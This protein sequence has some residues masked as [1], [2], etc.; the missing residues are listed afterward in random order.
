MTRRLAVLALL[1]LAAACHESPTD[2]LDD[3]ASKPHGRLSGIVT[4]GPNCPVETPTP[5]PTQP[6]AYSL[7]KILVYNEAKTSLLFTVDIDQFGLYTILL[8]PGRY[9][10]DLKGSGIDKTADLPKVVEIK[11]NVTTTLNVAIDTGIR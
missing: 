6:S 7:R 5:C 9:T 2:P 4:I 8:L 3:L 10:I 11:A 1:V